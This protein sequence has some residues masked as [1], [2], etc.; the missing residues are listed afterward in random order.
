MYTDT[1]LTKFLSIS[2]AMESSYLALEVYLSWEQQ[3]SL[4]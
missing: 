4:V 2:L 3:G 1:F